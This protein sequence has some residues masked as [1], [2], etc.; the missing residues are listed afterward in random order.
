MRKIRDILRSYFDGRLSP[1]QTALALKVSRGAVLR[2]LD[3]FQK[4]GLPYPLPDGLSDLEL[5]SRLYPSSVAYTLS[6]KKPHLAKEECAVIHREM[7][8][9]A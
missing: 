4:S 5:E 8:E 9:S 1:R 7:S 2:C 6:R 3:R